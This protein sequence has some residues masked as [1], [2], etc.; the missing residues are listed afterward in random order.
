MKGGGRAP[1]TLTSLGLFYPHDGMYARK[2]PCSSAPHARRWAQST[3]RVATATFWR[4]YIPSWW[5]NKPSLVRVGGCTPTPLHYI[6]HQV[7]SC[8][9][10]SSWEGRYTHPYFLIYPICTLWRWEEQKGVNNLWDTNAGPPHQEV[11]WPYRAGG[12]VRFL[13]F[14]YSLY[15]TDA[16]QQRLNCNWIFYLT[17][18]LRIRIRDWGL[19]DPWIRDPE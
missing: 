17:A 1:P 14:L 6:Y 15:S 9:V 5:K 19:F 2:Q 18:V 7:Q 16:M 8:G 13:I 3:H 12:C 10:C 4:R 11:F